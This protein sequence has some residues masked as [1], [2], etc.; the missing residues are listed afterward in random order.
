MIIIL[1]DVIDIDLEDLEEDVLV[2]N[3]EG[4]D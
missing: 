4:L 2:I 1:N 3:S